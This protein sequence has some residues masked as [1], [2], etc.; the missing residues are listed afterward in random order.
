MFTVHTQKLQRLRRLG[1]ADLTAVLCLL[2]PIAVWLGGVLRPGK[3][4]FGGD[5]AFYVYPMTAIGME[6]WRSGTVPLWTRHLQGGFPLLADGQGA[7]LYP[8]NVLAHLILPT[9]VAFGAVIVLQVC[10]AGVLM[11]VLM[12]HLGTGRWGA[13]LAGWLFVFAGPVGANLTTP[14]LNGVVWW[15]LLFLLANRLANRPTLPGSAL[16]GLVM[17]LG[18]LGGFP[19]TTLYGAGAAS[20]YLGFRCGTE[21]G[22]RWIPAIHAVGAWGLAVALGLGIAAIQLV[23]TL[24]MASFS[25]RAGG[26]DFALATQ[27]SMLPTGLAGL[28]LP[29]WKSGIEGWLAGPNLYIGLTGLACALLT[30]RYGSEKRILFFWFLGLLGCALSLG[31][32]NPV[33]PYLYTLPGLHFLRVPARFLYWTQFS[34]AVLSAIGLD[35]VLSSCAASIS[36]LRRLR[37]RLILL[38]VLVIAGTTAGSLLLR[39]ERSR[40]FSLAEAYTAR[41]LLGQPYRLQGEAYYQAKIASI[42]KALVHTIHPLNPQIIA[43]LVLALGAVGILSLPARRP[44]LTGLAQVLLVILAATDLWLLVGRPLEAASTKVLEPPPLAKLLA[45]ESQPSRLYEVV[46]QGDIIGARSPSYDRLSPNYNLLSGVSHVGAYSALGSRRYYD[47]LGS[48]G[49]VNLAFGLRP[50]ATDDV[51]RNLH[52]LNLLNVG[53]VVSGVSLNLPGLTQEDAGSVFLYRNEHALPRAFVV[54]D[55][56]TVNDA[57]QVLAMMHTPSFDP[58]S[59]VI[60]EATPEVEITGGVRSVARIVAY[61]DQFISLEADGPGWLVL[62]DLYYPGW[63]ARVDGKAVRIYRGNYVFRALPLAAGTHRVEFSF[64][65]R[66]FQWGTLVTSVSGLIIVA[67]LAADVVQTRRR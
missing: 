37:L 47:L 13:V 48:L 66:S 19:Q 65:S 20:L 40:L 3:I 11:Y 60:L 63:R 34:L 61:M 28:L 52:V 27:G 64:R 21:K 6:Q 38:A 15:P 14:A 4:I 49:G 53:Y 5:I 45:E 23:P 8:L 33:Y 25:V 35:R 43:S 46:T 42:Y 67:F 9:P 55:A 56:V 17:G 54:P 59:V 62:T 29:T 30:L 7:L 10:L 51:A 31:K 36:E 18:W 1:A 41:S 24:E 32:F 50:V 22:L 12:R 26:V 16:A 44:D 2:A 58:S 39:W 57:T